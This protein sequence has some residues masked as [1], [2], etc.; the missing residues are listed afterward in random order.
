MASEENNDLENLLDIQLIEQKESLSSIDEALLSDPSNPEL[1]SV[2][3]ELL[4]AIKEVEEGLLHLKRARL[5]EEADI[6][7]NGLNH[8]AGVKPEHL[9]PEKTEEK[10]DLDGSKCRFRHTDGRWYNGR[11]IGFEGSDSAKISFLTPTSESMM[12]CKFFMQ[13][14]CRFG[15]S[16]RSSHGLDVPISSLKNYEQTEWKQLMVGSKIWAVSGSKYDIWRKAELESWDDE[17]QVGGVVFRDDKS[18]AKLGSDSL[19]LS[20]YAQMTDDDG[21]EEEEEEDEQQS[22]S[23]S[24]DSVS[25]DYDEGS[26]QGIGFLESTNLPRGVQTDTALFAKW[27]NH[28]RGIASK[29]M[30]SMGYREGMGLGV[31]GQGILN[32]ILVK[33]LP[34]KR[35]LDYALE[36]IR[37]GECKSEKQKKKRSRGGKRKRGKKF[38]EAAKAAKQEEESKPDLFSLINEQIF[39]TRHEKVHSESVKNR[40][41]KGPVD[42][43]AL[44]EYQDEVRDLKLEMLKLEQMVNRNKKDLVV[45]EAAT[46]RLKEVRKALASTLACQAAASNAI[47]SKENEKKWLKF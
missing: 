7:L 44:V 47:V 23:D 33:V 9:E 18:S 38:A 46:R 16:C 35:S 39:P 14:R 1:L 28:T 15:S 45:S 25:S 24:E 26:P 3:E 31:S 30:A 21:E 22:A 19:A 17:L 36:H 27:E 13:Q 42:R 43:K 6:V 20:E 37:N 2:H 5:L 10:K 11:I 40:Q 29:M 41:N 4:S 12:I 34:A 8:D 32:P